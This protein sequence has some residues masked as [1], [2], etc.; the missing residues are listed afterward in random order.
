[1]T[2]GSSF[3]R[4]MSSESAVDP[5]EI[6]GSRTPRIWTPPLRELNPETSY[7]FDVA[8]FARAVLEEP[9]DPWQE[10]LVVHLG[11]LLP[12]DRPRFR[13]ALVLVAR[14]QGKSHLARVLTLYW[15]FVDQVPLVLGLN[16]TLAYAKEQ[17]AMVC[18]TATGNQWLARE[19]PRNAIRQTIG[20]ECLRTSSGSR[21]KIAAANRRAGRSLTIDRILADELREQQT[22]DAWN[23]SVNATNARRNAQIVAITNQGD[24]T[25]VVLD[26]LRTPALEYIET[27]NGDKRLGIF[28]WSAPAGSDPT[29]LEA[30]AM[31]C[32]DLGG[33][34]DPDALLG[35]GLRAKLAGGEELASFRTEVM[36]MRV[37]LLDPAI[38]PDRWAECETA[39]PLDLATVRDQVALCLDVSL[40]GSHASLIAAAEHEGL[41][42]VD[43][44]KAWTG[45]GCTKALRVE[46][47]GIVARVK[48]RVVGWF[49]MGPAAAISA[50]MAERRVKGWPPRRVKLAGLGQ[51]D[52]TAVCMALPGLVTAREIR[53]ADDPMLRAH[54]GSAQRLN[55]GDGFV[56][57]RRGTGP[58]DGA[59]AVA[60]AVHLARTLPPAPAKLV[61]L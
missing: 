8:D 16:A 10:W 26:S 29:D 18:Q 30:L 55:R 23:A 57:Q 22:W 25:A 41:V 40:D 12:D 38:D 59:Y 43:V 5:A 51:G 3:P 56:Y 50:D 2:N 34:T 11:E 54:I 28:E 46:L 27:G 39:D 20:E 35:A 33:R 32:P 53:H 60:G 31:A 7:G 44:V 42:H 1:M 49:P 24:D 4:S 36:C 48:P 9:L 58:I 14:Q 47:P 19:L 21:Y 17:W 13:V 61:V 15:M 37:A 52:V 45:F 6:R